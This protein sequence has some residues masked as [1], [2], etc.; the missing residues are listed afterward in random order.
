MKAHH[1]TPEQIEQIILMAW[2]DTI[3]FETIKRE[4]GLTEN[5]VVAFMRTH[6]S[7]KTYVRWRTR[8]E[9]RNGDRSKHELVSKVTSRRQ[10]F[11]I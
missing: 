6:Q 9:S 4:W 1:F 3:S 8:V 2:G 11:P 7:P 5:E 10:K